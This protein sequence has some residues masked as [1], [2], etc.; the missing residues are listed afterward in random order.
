MC[1]YWQMFEDVKLALSHF[2]WLLPDG[3]VVSVSTFNRN[4]TALQP[5]VALNSGTRNLLFQTIR[6]IERKETSTEGLGNALNSAIQVSAPPVNF[7][8]ENNS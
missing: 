5:S 2:V 6:G 4:V 3:I 1:S 7:K 8:M